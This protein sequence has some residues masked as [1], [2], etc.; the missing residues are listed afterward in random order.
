MV[1]PL[2]TYLKHNAYLK[3]IWKFFTSGLTLFSEKILKNQKNI[4]KIYINKIQNFT[5]HQGHQYQS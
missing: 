4:G 1:S 2:Q 3:V 5:G